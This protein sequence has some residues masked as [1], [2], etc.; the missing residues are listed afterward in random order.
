[1]SYLTQSKTIQRVCLL[2]YTRRWSVRRFVP[3]NDIFRRFFLLLR[4]KCTWTILIA[5]SVCFLKLS[6]ISSD[7]RCL[8]GRF[9]Y[10][11]NNF[12]AWPSWYCLAHFLHGD[13]SQGMQLY[14]SFFFVCL[15]QYWISPLVKIFEVKGTTMWPWVDFF[16]SCSFLH[17]SQRRPEHVLQRNLEG[18]SSQF[19]HSK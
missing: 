11:E 18:R 8:S 15:K 10:E 7:N 3:R 5:S 4:W 14:L 9:T 16:F 17:I 1:M 6:F 13:F 2:R 12:I 19:S